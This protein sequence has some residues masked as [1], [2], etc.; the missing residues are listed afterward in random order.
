FVNRHEMVDRLLGYKMLL[1]KMENCATLGYEKMDEQEIRALSDDWMRKYHPVKTQEPEE[2][3]EVKEE[4]KPRVGPH[5]PTSPHPED[6]QY[7]DDDV[8]KR[9]R[10]G[11]KTPPGS[12]GPSMA[13][14][15][16]NRSEMVEQLARTFGQ[17][18]FDVEQ[19]WVENWTKH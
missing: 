15:V 5:T 4:P 6:R 1:G 14:V 10:R 16:T 17:S 19:L 8:P 2:S 18:T 3:I 9:P 13:P 7:S 12:P 11:P